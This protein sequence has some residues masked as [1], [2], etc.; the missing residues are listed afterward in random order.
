MTEF[1]AHELKNKDG[2]PTGWID[3]EG[4][5][6]ISYTV[7]PEVKP[8]INMI[9]NTK[10][11]FSLHFTL[12]FHGEAENYKLFENQTNVLLMGYNNQTW[13]LGNE[14]LIKDA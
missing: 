10:G 4:Y 3:E 13:T 2:S 7:F 14:S 11:P 9:D 12:D 5:N 1:S 6:N 8:Y